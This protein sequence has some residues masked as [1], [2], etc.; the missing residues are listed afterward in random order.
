MT[1][2]FHD[3]RFPTGISRRSSG[4]PQRNTQI[5]TLSSGHEQ[6]N[7]R[8]ADS[9]R[10]FNAG[11]GMATL[12]DLASVISFFEQRRGRLFGFRWKDHTDYKSCLPSIEPAATD[13]PLG[14]GD[15]ITSQFQLVKFYG[16]GSSAWPRTITKPVADT[17]KVA[18]D[19]V[20]QVIGT[21]FTCDFQTGIIE[22]LPGHV[23]GI[24]AS[25]SAGFEFDVPVRFDQDQIEISL[26]AFQAGQVPD[27]SIIEIKI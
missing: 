11:Y 20:E 6:R 25:I 2:S 12:D 16:S 18:V 9:R 19:G 4:G 13:Q 8:W 1:N 26:D 27:I 24:D 17:V 10:H 3:T 21:H 5:V 7:T 22:F 23:P 14:T 15:G